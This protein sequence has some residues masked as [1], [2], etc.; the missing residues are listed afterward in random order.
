[1]KQRVISIT[2]RTNTL[3]TKMKLSM[4]FISRDQIS[5]IIRIQVH[6]NQG[7]L[8]PNMNKHSIKHSEGPSI[9][10]SRKVL[11]QLSCFRY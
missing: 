1:M 6:P 2:K 4:N 11:M 8:T 9:K 7:K 5:A 10:D 3:T